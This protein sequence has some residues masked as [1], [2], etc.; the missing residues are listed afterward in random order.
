MKFL[1]KLAASVLA[2]LAVSSQ[3]AEYGLS[4]DVSSDLLRA[5]VPGNPDSYDKKLTVKIAFESVI[6]KLTAGQSK[7]PTVD[8]ITLESYVKSIE[9]NDGSLTVTFDKEKT[10]K[11]LQ[12]RQISVYVSERPDVMMWI[13]WPDSSEGTQIISDSFG[14]A[15]VESFKTREKYYG[16]NAFFPIMDVDD[17]SV[18]T[19]ENVVAGDIDSIRVATERYGTPYFVVGS[20]SESGNGGYSL[21][22]GLYS[23][24]KNAGAIDSGEFAGTGS[25]LGEALASG[26][27]GKFAEG[28]MEKVSGIS[29]AETPDAGRVAME[30]T[31]MSPGVALVVISGKMDFSDVYAL[32]RGMQKSKSIKSFG[33]YQTQAD[34]NVYEI[35]FEGDYS[36]ASKALLAIKGV[37]PVGGDKIYNFVFDKTQTMLKEEKRIAELEEQCSDPANAESS[38][39]AAFREEVNKKEQGENAGSEESTGE[40]DA[41]PIDPNSIKDTSGEKL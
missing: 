11:L 25:E 21:Q 38:K 22:W 30:G 16:Q 33:L 34:Q 24:D 9:P 32:E 39:C 40:I 12:D 13:V 18:V 41:I 31:L 3:A 36:E 10:L 14:N 5:S 6:G 27:V 29:G 19:Y 20:A 2:V 28:H 35:T 8:A 7:A 17:S 37:H 23:S 1:S 15:F 4:S 26:I